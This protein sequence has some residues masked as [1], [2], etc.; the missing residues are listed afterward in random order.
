[1]RRMRFDDATC[2]GNDRR[3][4]HRGRSRSR[5]SRRDAT[6]NFTV[7]R[8][9]FLPQLVYPLDFGRTCERAY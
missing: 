3:N 9:A 7:N 6:A 2:N 5:E 4:N 8:A 1:M